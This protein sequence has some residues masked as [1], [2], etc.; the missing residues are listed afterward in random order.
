MAVD[1]ELDG[2][3]RKRLLVGAPD[4]GLDRNLVVTG[5]VVAAQAVL[6]YRRRNGQA[7][8]L[9]HV[10]RNVLAWVEWPWV[11]GFDHRPLDR[12]RHVGHGSGRGAQLDTACGDRT[13]RVG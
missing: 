2:I 13:G 5:V 10:E 1:V 9:D 6:G 7:D 4:E 3:G 12:R 11:D 8:P